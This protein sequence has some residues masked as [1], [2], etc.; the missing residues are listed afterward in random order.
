MS[1]IVRIYSVTHELMKLY[2]NSFRRNKDDALTLLREV[3]DEIQEDDRKADIQ[4][5]LLE[6]VEVDLGDIEGII[7][8]LNFGPK[9]AFQERKTIKRVRVRKRVTP[10]A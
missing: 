10:L 6:E 3:V 1:D 7:C 8:A 2:Q 5:V 9:I 4:Y